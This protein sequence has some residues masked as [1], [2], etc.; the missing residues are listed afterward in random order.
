MQRPPPNNKKKKTDTDMKGKRGGKTN[1][2]TSLMKSYR[3]SLTT[4]ITEITE[5]MSNSVQYAHLMGW[6]KKTKQN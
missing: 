6:G 5:L 3:D 4:Y 2:E 1:L